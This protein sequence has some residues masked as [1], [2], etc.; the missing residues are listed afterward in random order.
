MAEVDQVLLQD[1]FIQ[2]GGLL[3]GGDLLR[4]SAQAENTARRASRD[5]V[6]QY[7]SQQ[8][9]A[10]QNASCLGE[11]PGN[12]GGHDALCGLPLTEFLGHDEKMALLEVTGL[13][14]HLVLPRRTVQAVDDVSFHIDAGESVGLVGES[15]SGKSMTGASILRLLPDGGRIVSGSVRLDDHD[16][17]ALTEREMAQVRGNDIGIVFQDPMT[18]LN[19]TMTI[20]EQIAEAVLIHRR[21]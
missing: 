3:E 16:L 8:R 9:D 4:G 21:L 13:T 12:I 11:T 15:G 5:G 20:G 18:A 17:T 2:A 1:R 14:T 7:E 6:Q 19:P 10:E